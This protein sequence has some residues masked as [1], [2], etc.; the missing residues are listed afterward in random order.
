MYNNV[1]SGVLCGW[2]LGVGGRF[3]KGNVRLQYTIHKQEG[4]LHLATGRDVH[5][6]AARRENVAAGNAMQA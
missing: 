5:A 6:A 3:R 1:M 4:C 2:G